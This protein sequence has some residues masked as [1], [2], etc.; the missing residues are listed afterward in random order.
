MEITRQIRQMNDPV[1]TQANLSP[2]MRAK[3][4][5]FKAAGGSIYIEKPAG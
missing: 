5:E 1:P 4:A 3:S 2:K